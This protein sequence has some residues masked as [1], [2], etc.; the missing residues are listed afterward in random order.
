MAWDPQSDAWFA[1]FADGEGSFLLSH[2]RAPKRG[3]P[4]VC[5]RFTLQLRADDIGILRQLCDSFGGSL[6]YVKNDGRTTPGANPSWTWQVGGRK[7]LLALVAY[8]DHHP[9]RAKKAADFAIWREAVILYVSRGGASA[10]PELMALRA[11]LIMGRAYDRSSEDLPELVD[12]LQL[13]L[14]TRSGD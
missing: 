12:Q 9:L 10:Y 2:T 3:R 11:S 13:M 6:C 7:A 8:F 5:P 1:G 14:E 4:T